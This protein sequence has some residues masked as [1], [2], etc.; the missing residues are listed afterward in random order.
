M[1]VTAIARY[2]RFLDCC[3]V[4][5]AVCVAEEALEGLYLQAQSTHERPKSS[6]NSTQASDLHM[7][8]LG[9]SSVPRIGDDTENIIKHHEAWRTS[10]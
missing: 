2:R 9:A 1:L 8:H 6:Q 4:C 5:A 3:W 7:Y 10:F